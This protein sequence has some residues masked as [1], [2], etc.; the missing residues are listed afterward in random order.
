MFKNLLSMTVAAAA[1]TLSVN[2]AAAQSEIY[3]QHFNLSEVTLLDGPMK[4][5]MEINDELLLKYDADRLM[6]PF[7]RQAGLTKD[8][9]S[10]YYEWEKAHPSFSNWGLDSWSLEG[11]VGGHYVTALALAYAATNDAGMKAKMKERLDY[12]LAI[13][14][15][16]QDAYENN[17][18]GLKGFIGG[19]PINQVWTGLYAR[20]L[21]EFRRYGGWVPFYCQHKVLAGLRDAYLYTGSTLAKEL[22][23]GLSDWSINVVSKLSDNEMQD[24]LGW[25]HGGMNETLVDAYKIFGE[26]KY[27]NGAKKY[28]RRTTVPHSLTASTLTR[29]CLST[30]VS[31]V[32]GRRTRR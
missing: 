29:R 3:P 5:M 32:H 4:T 16:C 15:D 6:T 25:E 17:T 13:M 12:C 9:S 2:P 28:S 10:K 19:Q 1:L 24:I 20:D 7:I 22:F 18:Q 27:L 21:T 8:S 30:S 23:K 31:N 11:H 26:T 14:K